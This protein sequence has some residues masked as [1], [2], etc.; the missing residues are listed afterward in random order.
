MRTLAANLT[1]VIYVLPARRWTRTRWRAMFGVLAPAGTARIV[2]QVDEPPRASI[3]LAR[4]SNG[5]T[6]VPQPPA[7]KKARVTTPT[8]GIK[9][10]A[11]MGCFGRN[12]VR[13]FTAL[14]KRWCLEATT[15]QARASWQASG[16]DRRQDGADCSASRPARCPGTRQSWAPF[17]LASTPRTEAVLYVTAP[18][19]LRYP[20]GNEGH[21]DGT[22][23]FDRGLEACDR[24]GCYAGAAFP[25]QFACQSAELGKL[26]IRL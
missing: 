26:S 16:L 9:N 14:R 17:P 18:L 2:E 7:V 21:V 25:E 13:Q 11:T 19:G 10:F 4:I 22:A 5:R 3:S 24:G 20:G 8:E 23:A 6:P 15:A 12:A 1:E